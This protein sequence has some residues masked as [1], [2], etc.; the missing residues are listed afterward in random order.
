VRV[1]DE[2]TKQP[3][4]EYTVTVVRADGYTETRTAPPNYSYAL[5]LA[6][7]LDGTYAVEVTKSGYQDW[8]ANGVV[9]TRGI[10]GGVQ[11]VSLEAAMVPL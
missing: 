5:G 6:W 3:V 8:R 1:T 11:P 9:V 2:V 7:E 4:L 10:C